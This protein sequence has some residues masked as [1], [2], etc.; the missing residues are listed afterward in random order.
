MFMKLNASDLI[1]TLLKQFALSVGKIHLLVFR[2]RISAPIISLRFGLNEW[3]WWDQMHPYHAKKSYELENKISSMR[4][5]T[6]DFLHNSIGFNL[7]P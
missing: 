2:G 3:V 1:I 4:N 7:N 6:Q 5:N